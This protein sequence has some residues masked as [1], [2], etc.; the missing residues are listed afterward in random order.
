MFCRGCEFISN[1][2]SPDLVE[3]REAAQPSDKRSNPCAFPDYLALSARKREAGN[4]TKGLEQEEP[5]P[6][7]SG[8]QAADLL[9]I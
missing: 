3:R 5:M 6:L 7:N 4:L 8:C 1:D 2:L 9:G